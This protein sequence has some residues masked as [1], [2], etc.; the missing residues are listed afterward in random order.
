[1]QQGLWTLSTTNICWRYYQCLCTSTRRKNM[2]PNRVR[3]VT[4]R[5]TSFENGHGP[6]PGTWRTGGPSPFP[7]DKNVQFSDDGLETMLETC[8]RHAWLARSGHP[9]NFALRHIPSDDQSPKVPACESSFRPQGR[10]SI[11][12]LHRGQLSWKERSRKFLKK[13][14]ATSPPIKSRSQQSRTGRHRS[15]NCVNAPRAPEAV[16]CGKASGGTKGPPSA[17][18]VRVKPPSLPSHPSCVR[19][20]VRSYSFLQVSHGGVQVAGVWRSIAGQVPSQPLCGVAV[21]G[22]GGLSGACTATPIPLGS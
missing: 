2:A 8:W 1:M 21:L 20:Q 10:A 14:R 11:C 5:Y 6:V 13:H 4:R 12:N 15:G 16:H 3:S 9:F 18:H 22:F 7:F 17:W 19:A